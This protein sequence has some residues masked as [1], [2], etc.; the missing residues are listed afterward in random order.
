MKELSTRIIV[1]LFGIPVLILCIWQGGYLFFTAI[2]VM[3]ILGQYELYNLMQTKDLSPQAW[4]GFLMSLV[5]LY[6]IAFGFHPYLISIFLLLMLLIM[7]AEMYRNVGSPLLNTA[8]T[9]LGVVY[10]TLFLG[11][12][13]YLRF[14]FEEL[15]GADRPNAAA[16]FILTIFVSVWVCDTM[17]YFVGVTLGKHRLFERVSP[18]KSIEGA[19]AGVTGAVLI[20]LSIRWLN[21]FDMEY[22]FL[23]ISGLIVGVLGQFGDLVESWLKRDAHVKDS[24]RILPGHG[25]FLDR[26]DSLSYISPAFL[27]LFLLWK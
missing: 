1:A 24:S 19:L 5:L 23:L 18:K 17:A 16:I 2:V 12:M 6:M 15:P 4:S 25:G 7:G 27:I 21:L 9:L 11:S 20:F 8:G 26:F 13:L 14:H 3:S 10:P 22:L